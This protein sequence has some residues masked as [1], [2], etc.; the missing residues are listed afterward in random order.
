MFTNRVIA[1]KITLEVAGAVTPPEEIE[2]TIAHFL[3]QPLDYVGTLE[4]VITNLGPYNSF[5]MEDATGA[6]AFRKSGINAANAPFAVGDKVSGSFKKVDYNGL[7]QAELQEDAPTVEAGPHTLT[8]PRVNLNEVGLTAEAL[9]PYQSRL[10]TGELSVKTIAAKDGK[11]NITLLLTDGTNDITLRL[12]SRLP[13]FAEFEFLM[14]LVVGD[15]VVLDGAV[16]GW[17]NGP[18]LAADDAAQLEVIRQM[19]IEAFLALEIGALG[20]LSGVITNMGPHNSFGMEDATGAVAFRKS[21]INSVNAPFAVGDK[22]SGTFKKVDYNGLMQAE[23]QEDAPTVEAGPHTLT[24]PRVNLNEVGL[25]AEALAPYQSRLVTGELSVK[26]IAAKD[27]KGNITLLLTD[28]TNDITLRLDYRLAKI[29]EFEYL[30]ALAVGDV[31][32][33]D[34]ALIGWYNVPQLAA[35]D[36][37]QVVKKVAS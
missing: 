31:V 9:A 17:F 8:L 32:V 27:G 15:V 28:G 14:D 2:G 25:T 35:D 3:A 37:V 22:V 30:M 5:G 29:A 36:P 1:S 10:V 7:M 23:L 20:K 24:L 4:A 21:G 19:S 33:L 34:G 18:Q 11:G 12:D 16:I 26:T 6:V 13:K